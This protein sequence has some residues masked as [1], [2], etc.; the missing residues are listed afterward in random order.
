MPAAEAATKQL[1]ASTFSSAPSPRLITHHHHTTA[2]VALLAVC[3]V[4]QSSFRPSE[5]KAL[6]KRQ[7]TQC[8]EYRSGQASVMYNDLCRSI[9]PTETFR[10][11]SIITPRTTSSPLVCC[12]WSATFTNRFTFHTRSGRRRIAREE[13]VTN[14]SVVRPGSL[15]MMPLRRHLR[16][17]CYDFYFL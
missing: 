17:P 15:V 1:A 16:R 3:P 13:K 12:S 14:I 7:T 9:P 11:R 8:V 5:R 6:G 4:R 10:N 2:F